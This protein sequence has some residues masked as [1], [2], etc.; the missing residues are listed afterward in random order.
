LEEEGAVL[1][2]EADGEEGGEGFFAVLGEKGAVLC[3]G[4]GVEVNDAEN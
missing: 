1:R 3:A 2:G 4:E